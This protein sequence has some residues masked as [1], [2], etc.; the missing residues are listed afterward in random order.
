MVSGHDDVLE[1]AAYA[2]PS[3]LGEDEVAV[4]LK[5]EARLAPE[6]LARYCE[7]RMASFMVPRFVRFLDAF[8]KTGTK[9]TMKYELKAQ[10][11]TPDTWDSEAAGVGP[12]RQGAV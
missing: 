5:P 4:V 2:L 3:E 7:A 11:V 8:P 10:G 1:S 9:R 12:K 6:T